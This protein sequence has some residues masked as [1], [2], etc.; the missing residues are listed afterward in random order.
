MWLY[1][2][3]M[4]KVDIL[5]KINAIPHDKFPHNILIIPD[6]NGRWA[7]KQDKN[8]SF[9]HR[10]AS[11]VIKDI[12]N[13]LKDLDEIET[14]T[15]WGFSAD[16]WKRSKI[17][18]NSLMS[19]FSFMVNDLYKD[20]IRDETRFIHIGRKDRIPKKLADILQK[21]EFETK[22]LKKR[23]LA[24]AIDF[25]GEDQMIRMIDK[26][27]TLSKDI[28]INKDILESLKDGA[29][30][31]HTSDLIIRTSGE[32][33]TSD[34]GW[35]NGKETELYFLDKLFPDVKT[36]DILD[37]IIDFSKRERRM[38]KR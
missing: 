19:I 4:K 8:V 18:V 28:T 3:Y 33:R 9:G 17:E 37:A 5:N 1:K 25:G 14:L 2:K 20:L 36:E 11:Y 38:G 32:V 7:K 6:G 27:R 30:I 13:D 21:V 35:F 12:I 23:I 10:K 31:I 15:I 29:G 16:N 26:A 34:I 22:D 24:L